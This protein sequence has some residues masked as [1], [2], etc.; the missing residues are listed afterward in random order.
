MLVMTSHRENAAP[1]LLQEQISALAFSVGCNLH[2]SPRGVRCL[3]YKLFHS[4]L[5][6]KWLACLQKRPALQEVRS[7]T[8]CRRN[9]NH[10]AP[11]VRSEGVVTSAA[12]SGGACWLLPGSVSF[13]LP[14]PEPLSACQKK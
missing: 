3:L 12:P 5:I 7:L 11:S 4:R 13:P 14:E 10:L 9:N 8:G 6:K 2:V 1:C